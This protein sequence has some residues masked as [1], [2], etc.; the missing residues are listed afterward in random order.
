MPL[1]AEPKIISKSTNTTV[2]AGMPVTVSCKVKNNDLLYH[3]LLWKKGDVFVGIDDNHSLW[4]TQHDNSTRTYEL[5]V[6]SAVDSA[7]YTCLLMSTDGRVVSSMTQHVFVDGECIM[8]VVHVRYYSF[9]SD[10]SRSI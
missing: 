2:Y 4:F 3:Q 9:Y 8:F 10:K 6:H 5:T 1:V 7:S